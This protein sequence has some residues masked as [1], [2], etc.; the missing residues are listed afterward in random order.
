MALKAFYSKSEDVPKEHAAFYKKVDLPDGGSVHR[1]DVEKTD[2][3]ELADTGGLLASLES[4]RKA[5][6]KLKQYGDLTPEKAKEHADRVAALE[7]ELE[8]LKDSGK[9]GSPDRWKARE[10]E[11]G[12]LHSE[13]KRKLEEKAN[14]LL[15]QLDDEL[16]QRTAI[17]AL[18][19]HG[20]KQAAKVLLPHVVSQIGFSDEN[21]R[22]R[23]FVKRDDGSP[24]LTS[25]DNGAREMNVED[26]VR[27]MATGEFSK[28]KDATVKAPAAPRNGSVAPQP[29]TPAT[30]NQRPTYNPTQA[31]AEAFARKAAAK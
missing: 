2:G 4:E 8:R 20:F 30:D 6:R 26:L 14:G 21:G 10:E 15:K 19:A 18:E 23:S 28:W 3:W 1:L 12:R 11:I 31:L 5:G 17:A 16:G 29:A 27:E 22:R 25:G 13:E 24:R 9:G 7:E